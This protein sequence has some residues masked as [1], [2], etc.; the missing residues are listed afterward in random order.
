MGA[1]GGA[2]LA[3]PTML[4]MQFL[5]TSNRPSFGYGVAAMG[6]LPPES[7]ATVLFG[8]IFGSLRWTYDYWGP[9]WHIRPEGTWTDRAT[10]Y[11]FAGTVPAL[12]C[13]G[14]GIAGG[15][16][17]AREFRFFLI[18]GVAR[19]PL[20]ARPLHARSSGSSSTMF[21]ASSS[22]AARPTR[23]S[24]STSPSPSRPATSCTATLE[25]G[26]PRLP[27]MRASRSGL[28]RRRRWPVRPG[29]SL[30]AIGNAPG[31]ACGPAT[32]PTPSPR[33]SASASAS[34]RSRPESSCAAGAP[35][36][37][38]RRGRGGS[39]WRST[40]GELIWRNAA[41]SLNA[42][43]ADA[44]RGVSEAA[45]GAASGPAAAQG[46]TR[47]APRP[48]RAARASRSSAS[49]AHGRTPP[50]CSASRT[51]S[52]T[53]RCASP[54]TSAP[55]APARTPSIRTCAQ[56]PGTFRGYKCRLAGL[57]G[58]EYLVLDRPIEKSAAPLPAPAGREA[59]YGSGTMWIYRLAPERAPRLCGHA[60]DRRSNS[61]SVLD[62][63]ELP[64]FDRSHARR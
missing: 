20:R 38:A 28:F 53:T 2:L 13:S 17:F 41:S 10:N 32:L 47:R 3:V 8:N 16:L 14:T 36:C 58:L 61:E 4:T 46:G 64:E 11:L 22:T 40:G 25:D 1:V 39:S 59:L 49:A 48:G 45:A 21:R 19:A 56:F 43:P 60:T 52:A 44:L 42:E 34:P 33:D 62:Q 30:A 6:S 9:D 24:S 57:L 26:A 18:F 63:E 35:P 23:P 55:S 51:P 50:W 31:F 54:I 5:A 7:L 27:E 37:A 12:L 15:R 29:R